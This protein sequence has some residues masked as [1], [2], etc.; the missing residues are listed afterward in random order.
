MRAEMVSGIGE[1][2]AE[3]FDRL[4]PVAG[5]GAAGSHG[6]T[7]LR[8]RDGRWRTRYLRGEQDGRLIAFVPC[9]EPRGDRWPDPA[10]DPGA[11]GLSGAGPAFP[12]ERVLTVGGHGDLRTGFP[13]SAEAR[14]PERLRPL[15]G[16]LARVAA[17]EDRGLSFPYVYESTRALISEACDDAAVWAPLGLEGHLRGGVCRPDWA[18]G[19]DRHQRRN[20]RKDREL[21]AEAKV[22]TTVHPWSEVADRAAELI[23][24]HNDRKGRFDHREFVLMRARNWDGCPGVEYLAFAA[25][26][27]PVEG[28]VTACVWRD[29]LDLHEIGLDGEPGTERKAAYLDLAVHAP[30]RYA[31]ARGLRSIRLGAAATAVKKGRGAVFDRL[32]GGVLDVHATRRLAAAR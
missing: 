31:R 11:W 30:L 22:R 24:R 8:E 9:Y 15:I 12:P 32:Y 28:Y 3:E 7:A 21:I 26:C 29:E 13:V 25:R 5:A 2:D 27:G 16:A 14:S 17:E 19:L 20:L 18:D 1:V 23:A 4:D 10:Y 6:W